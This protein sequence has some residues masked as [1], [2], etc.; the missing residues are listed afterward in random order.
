LTFPV[1]LLLL[2]GLLGLLYLK[3]LAKL[4]SILKQEQASS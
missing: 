4:R 2:R 3:D 1:V